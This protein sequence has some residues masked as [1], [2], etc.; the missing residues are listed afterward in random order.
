MS[1]SKDYTTCPDAPPPRYPFDNSCDNNN[2]FDVNGEQPCDHVEPEPENPF[3]EEAV[4][5]AFVK[6]VFGILSVMLL[7]TTSTVAAFVFNEK[8][9]QWTDPQTNV[10]PLISAV[11]V[12]LVVGI[13]LACCSNVRRKYPIN[14]IFLALLTLSTS[15]MVGVIS[16]GYK[17]ESVVLAGGICALAC[18]SLVIFA[19]TTKIDFTK[20]LGMLCLMVWVFFLWGFVWIIPGY[21]NAERIY[22]LVGCVLFML[23][24]V[25]DVQLII[26]GKRHSLSPEEYIYAAMQIYLDV[27]NIFL[28][29]LQIFGERK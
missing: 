24:L 5:K 6:K 12:Y 26:G 27:V 20:F 22:A 19:M 18:G 11:V 8:L 3:G 2:P 4:R 23:F 15:Y 16:G 25:I 14:Y 7:V 1:Y 10:I 9:Q 21:S 17:A 13:S 28:Y 29:L